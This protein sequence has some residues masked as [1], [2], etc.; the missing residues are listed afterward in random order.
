ME[1]AL[2]ELCMAGYPGETIMLQ[3]HFN[4]KPHSTSVSAQH[5]SY[6]VLE[7]WFKC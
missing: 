1:A 5:K 7:L 4:I 6:R 3:T 2:Y